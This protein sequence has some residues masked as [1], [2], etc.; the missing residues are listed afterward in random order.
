MGKYCFGI[1]VGG[2]SVKCGLFQTD[3]V[4]VEKWE[5][6]TRK[7]NSG[8]A[9]LPDI[10]KTIL[11][12]IAERK[13]DKEEVDGV[14]I[15]V[16]GPVNERGEVPC[17]VNLFWGFKEVTKELTELTG[18]PSKAGND[19]NVAALGEAWKGAAA[20]AK[21]VILVTLG[22]GVG[23]G[24]IVDGKIVGG[25]HGAGGEIGHAAVNHEEK[26]A[27]NCGNC[28]CLEQYASATGI[29]RVAQRTLA[30]TDEQTVLRKFTKLS[31]KNVLDAFKEGD[32]VACDVMAQ[33]GEMLGGTLAMFA[34]VTDPEHRSFLQLSEM[35]QVFTDLHVW[36]LKKHK[37]LFDK[38]H[39]YRR[40]SEIIKNP[41]FCRFR[42]VDF[43]CCTN[44]ILKCFCIGSFSY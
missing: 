2:T 15:G 32:K 12:K 19:A 9:I 33:V 22:T 44:I 21:N 13:L 18:L 26:E 11:D 40:D 38:P 29:V 7:E 42:T 3:G 37:Y 20:G 30:A 4:L 28:G 36:L 6:P 34:C 41:Q 27:C 35:M 16:P 43:L 8:E 39:I 24:I 31:A 1:D 17:A 23:G 5:I 25:A 10:A 14:G